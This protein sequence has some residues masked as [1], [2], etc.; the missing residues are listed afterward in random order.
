MIFKE[1][2]NNVLKHSD[3]RHAWLNIEVT[4]DII[5]IELSDDGKGFDTNK[6]HAGKG[7]INIR[8]RSARLKGDVI[9][10]SEPGKNTVTT[11]KIQQPV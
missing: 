7:I 9:I 4:E 8:N 10:T 2:L 6:S 3:A 1:L 5:R 11:L